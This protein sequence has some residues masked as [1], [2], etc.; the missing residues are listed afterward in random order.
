MRIG[1]DGLGMQ[2]GSA[3][4]GIG[5]YL[6]HLTRGLADHPRVELVLYLSN[7]LPVDKVP[8]QRLWRLIGKPHL[9]YSHALAA[10]G[11][12][13]PDKLDALV[14]GSPF[15]THAR[16]WLPEQCRCTVPVGSIAYDLVP[17]LFPREYLDGDPYAPAYRAACDVLKDYSFFLSLSES[18]S[19][20][21]TRMFSL[22]AEVSLISAAIDSTF[23]CRGPGD[24]LPLN[25][26]G[27]KP[28]VLYMG[29]Q[30]ARKNLNGMI[31]AFASLPLALREP[32]SLVIVCPMAAERR[33]AL[34]ADLARLGIAHRAV[35]HDR[36]SDDDLRKLYRTCDAFVFPSLYEGF[37]LPILEAMACGAPC[38]VGN[39]SSQP[40]VV[41]DAAVLVDANNTASI[42]DGLVAVLSNLTLSATLRQAAIAQAARFSW[43]RT[44]DLTVDA[45]ARFLGR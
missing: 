44:A 16:H 21:F 45:L 4:R 7:A 23:F 1:L 5:R 19:R 14:I 27:S 40:E 22:A 11:Y 30:E 42:A 36:V 33:V 15:E 26:T 38:V 18:T 31:H 13:N 28:F 6:R 41:G 29:Q 35:I 9:S 34:N 12:S 8:D 25:L 17:L 37:G 3:G 20:D 24:I 2:S 43:T 39:N 10:T 32:R